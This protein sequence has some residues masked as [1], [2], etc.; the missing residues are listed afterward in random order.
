[1][2]YSADLLMFGFQFMLPLY[3]GLHLSLMCLAVASLK[4][5]CHCC[6][7]S[8]FSP[9][10][11]LASRQPFSLVYGSAYD[12]PFVLGIG[13]NLVGF[14]ALGGCDAI[15]PIFLVILVCTFFILGLI[16]SFF[17]RVANKKYI[18]SRTGNEI[19]AVICSSMFLK[20]V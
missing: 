2:V 19:S 4:L 5:F 17:A 10:F 20:L 13:A 7:F 12:C 15:L 6:F 11:G 9:L 16:K 8:K 14:Y 18:N 3:F 1:M